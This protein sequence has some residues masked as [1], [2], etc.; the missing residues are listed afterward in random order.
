VL[1]LKELH[2]RLDVTF[3]AAYGWDADISEDEILARL[4]ALNKK[5]AQD[6][7]R[8]HVLWLRPEYQIPRFG[9]PKERA[10]L[11]LV[12][13][14]PGQEAE[15]ALAAKSAFPTDDVAQ[16]AAVMAVLAAATGPQN[17]ISVASSFRQGRRNLPKVE[18]V[19]AAL[20]RMGFVATPD[21][22]SFTFRRPN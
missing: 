13:A 22:Q 3:A 10:E 8:G 1:V 14:A 21:G 17:A 7:V 9:S 4:V 5:R 16:T 11:D 20:T 15:E 18:A 12:G 6:E 2:D 19:L